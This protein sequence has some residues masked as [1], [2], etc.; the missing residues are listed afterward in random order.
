MLKKE[1]KTN[2]VLIKVY[3]D[4]QHYKQM[5]RRLFIKYLILVLL[6]ISKYEKIFK[7]LKQICLVFKSTQNTCLVLFFANNNLI[8][9]NA[10]FG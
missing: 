3:F 4:K 7:H 9:L 10:N 5:F 8:G 6:F 2:S 1:V